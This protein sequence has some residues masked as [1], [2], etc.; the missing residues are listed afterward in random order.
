MPNLDFGKEFFARYKKL[1]LLL[2]SC[3]EE[4]K[5]IELEKERKEQVQNLTENIY[6]SGYLGSA[7]ISN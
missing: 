2:E 7:S 3:K 4:I 6:V 1:E 5:F